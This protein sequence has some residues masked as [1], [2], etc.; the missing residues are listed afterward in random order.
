[1]NSSSAPEQTLL[2]ADPPAALPGAKRMTGRVFM[3]CDTPGPDVL[4][5]QEIEGKRH[6]PVW[7]EA[8]EIEYIARCRE[9]AQT[10]ARDIIAQAMA[11]A[12]EDAEAI[13]AAARQ[14]MAAI[15]E[16]ARQQAYDETTAK[17][18][19]EFQAQFDVMVATLGPL[20]ERIQGL[21]QEVWQA[22]RADFVTL[23]KVFTNKALGVQ[24]ETRRAEVLQSLMDEA[25]AKLDAARDF[26]LKVAPQDLEM[27]QELMTAAKAAR[28]DLG[29]WRL[30]ADPGLA[31]G[32]VTLETSD[33]LCDNG[34]ESRLELIAP[35]LEQLDLPEDRVAAA[36]SASQSVDR[37]GPQGAAQG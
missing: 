5:I 35:V 26:V 4:T 31:L 36:Q 9:K 21:G 2:Q 14:E 13:R 12:E 33:L 6:R 3:G 1:M 29:Q 18:S 34:V 20:L 11:K 10:I 32:G 22:R 15:T 37:S 24:M 27:A 17:F 28:P 8:T 25:V 7:D 30:V 16:Q 23:A 19:A